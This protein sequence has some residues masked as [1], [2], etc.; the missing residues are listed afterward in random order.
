[1]GTR[2]PPKRPTRGVSK[3]IT[4]YELQITRLNFWLRCFTLLGVFCVFAGKNYSQTFD[5]LAENIRHGSDE[6][7]RDALIQIR[8]LETAEASRIA[9]PALVDSSEIVRA[10]AA[11]SV[12]YL[13]KDEAFAVLIPQLNDKKEFVR[14]ET[15]YALGL[16]RSPSAIAPL[17]RTFKTDKSIEVKNACLIALGEIGD[18]SAVDFLAQILQR[19]P[20]DNNAFERRNAARSIGQIAQ[21]IQTGETKIITPLGAPPV[22]LKIIE[23]AV[24][25]NLSSKFPEFRNVVPILIKIF[26]SPNEADDTRRETAF[27]LGAIGDETAVSVLQNVKTED[28]YLTQI[29]AEALKKLP[30][31]QNTE[32]SNE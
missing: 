2:P 14:R 5:S 19:N 13:P 4:N 8:N 9:V 25:S 23:T 10:T 22:E 31:T 29:C 30:K 1:M 12:I 17:E 16:I 26:Q 28:N 15:V 18:V 7:K 20:N 21:I 32:K 27:A 6:Q 3:R 11:Y 24:Y